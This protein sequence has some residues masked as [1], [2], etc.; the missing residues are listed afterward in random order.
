MPAYT[1][2]SVGAWTTAASGSATLGPVA[3]PAGW[4]AGDLGLML[5]AARS[6]ASPASSTA[7][8]WT[9]LQTSQNGQLTLFGRILQGGDTD[10]TITFSATSSHAAQ[11]AAF[12]GDVWSPVSTIKAHGAFAN[13]GNEAAGPIYPGL[14][15]TTAD[16]LVIISAQKTKTSTSDGATI[17]AEPGFTEIGETGIAGNRAFVVWNYV[18]QTTATNIT[19]GTYDFT[20]TV[21]TQTARKFTVALKT[22]AAAGGVTSRLSLLGVG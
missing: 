9:S 16:C 21:E 15:I 7:T 14:T 8:G 4:Q 17:N 19:S 20:G 3:L 11:I 1:F 18:Q 10:P 2:R 22:L 12:Y 5:A 13:D 6:D